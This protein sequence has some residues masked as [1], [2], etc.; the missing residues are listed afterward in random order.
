MINPTTAIRESYDHIAEEYARRIYRELE[1]KPFDREVLHRFA[2]EV[3]GRG[4]VCDIGCGP[5]HVTRYLQNAG[6][7]VFGLDISPGMVELAR[8]LNPGTRFVVGDM[9][10]L[11]LPE[12][13]LTGAVVFYAIVN[14]QKEF[15]LAVF[16]EMCRVLQSGGLLLLAFHIGNEVVHVD[17]LWERP[18]SLDFFYFQTEEI[19]RFLES[20]GFKVEQAIER[21]PYAPDVEHQSRRAYIT[22]RKP[23][24]QLT[25]D[26]GNVV[27]SPN[28]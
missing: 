26:S 4:Q 13:G 23:S 15:L 22:A 27:V 12:G 14:I 9:L 11:D 17:K 3:E 10:A 5:G 20:A 24:T 7:D 6:A 2:Q 21:E 1:G 25:Q 19:C 16:R 18:V 8:Q 28:R